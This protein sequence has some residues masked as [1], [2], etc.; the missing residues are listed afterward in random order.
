MRGLAELWR[1]ESLLKW[2]GVNWLSMW[3]R[4]ESDFYLIHK[5]KSI[6]VELYI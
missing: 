5:Q 6:P 4:N 2:P 3:E 1:E